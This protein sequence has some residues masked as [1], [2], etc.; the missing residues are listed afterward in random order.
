MGFMLL[1]DPLYLCKIG[2]DPTQR[3]RHVAMALLLG[4]TLD[5]FTSIRCLQIKHVVH[6]NPVPSLLPIDCP[7]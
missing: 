4:F 6:S 5:M 3:T 2:G 7:V 1:L